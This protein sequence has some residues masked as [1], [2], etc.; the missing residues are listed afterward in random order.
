MRSQKAVFGMLG[1]GILTFGIGLPL[2]TAPGVLPTPKQVYL[3]SDRMSS[4]SMPPVR[5]I[6]S[7]A[8]AIDP[9]HMTQCHTIDLYL[10][11]PANQLGTWC[12]GFDAENDVMPIRGI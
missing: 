6:P 8:I 7:C 11:F 5:S 3:A 9:G 1:F 4:F 2:S 10:A 12:W